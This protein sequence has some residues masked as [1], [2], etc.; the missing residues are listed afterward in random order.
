MFG[1]MPK[2][3]LGLCEKVQTSTDGDTVVTKYLLYTKD[4]KEVEVRS[5]VAKVSVIDAKIT[6]LQREKVVLETITKG[7]IGEESITK[8]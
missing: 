1:F 8:L 2:A 3:I 4:G 7:E 5:K 6:E